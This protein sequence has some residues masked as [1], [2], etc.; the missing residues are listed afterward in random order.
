MQKI[1]MIFFSTIPRSI[2]KVFKLFIFYTTCLA[3][4]ESF[5]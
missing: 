5:I 3:G 2:L 1:N 4:N